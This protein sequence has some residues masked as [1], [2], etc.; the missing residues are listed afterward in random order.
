MDF[1]DTIIYKTI[2]GNVRNSTVAIPV[3]FSAADISAAWECVK[4]ASH[5]RLQVEVPVSTV[6]MEYLYHVKADKML[7]KS[8]TA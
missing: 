8:K 2:S 4:D 7:E 1:Q 5:P 6:Q 3:G